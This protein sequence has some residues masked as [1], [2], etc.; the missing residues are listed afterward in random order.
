MSVLDT[1]PRGRRNRDRDDRVPASAGAGRVADPP[2]SRHAGCTFSP[3]RA[4]EAG[5]GMA[6][7]VR[8]RGPGEFTPDFVRW[9]AS[10]R[11][12]GTAP[13]LHSAG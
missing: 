6:G 3:R 10:S 1:H 7:A 5:G 9:R 13:R 4:G 12:A 11:A 8:A 2:G